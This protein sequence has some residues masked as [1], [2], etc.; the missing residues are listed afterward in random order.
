[1][2]G[3]DIVNIE[4]IAQKVNSPAFISKVFTDNEIDYY[5]KNGKRIETLAG[6]FAAKEAVA[7]ALSCGV[8]FELT[9]IEV[10]H[11]DSGSPYVAI[12]NKAKEVFCKQFV[13]A[14]NSATANLHI[15]IS[16]DS[17]VAVAA[18]FVQIV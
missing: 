9:D 14:N 5:N 8:I 6:F 7:K 11:K 1:M 16:H 12:H 10:L 4:R 3:I 18:C 13:A 15:T 2:I 17:G